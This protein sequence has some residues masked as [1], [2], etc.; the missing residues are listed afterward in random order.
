[1]FP[2]KVPK[3]AEA[4]HPRAMCA[5]LLAR[6]VQSSGAHLLEVSLSIE[7]A[8]LAARCEAERLG[9]DLVLVC[10]SLYLL[11]DVLK[12][13]RAPEAFFALERRHGLSV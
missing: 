4:A 10:G 3:L 5:Q 6:T 12:T 7:G 11:G 9:E 1:M 8:L 2:K 13:L